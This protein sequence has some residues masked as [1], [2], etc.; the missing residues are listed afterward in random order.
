MWR[1][2]L[3]KTKSACCAF[4]AFTTN[5][6]V[7]LTNHR[8]TATASTKSN[9]AANKLIRAFLCVIPSKMYLFNH[10]TLKREKLTLP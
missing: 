10:H 5:M 2:S 7:G 3:F 4:S 1:L 8:Q 9:K 6:F